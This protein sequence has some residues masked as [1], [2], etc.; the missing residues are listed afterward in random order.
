MGI[1]RGLSAF[2]LAAPTEVLDGMTHWMDIREFASV[3][4]LKGSMSQQNL[5]DPGA[6]VRVA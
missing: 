3:A 4:R 2:R 6:F 5:P 1:S